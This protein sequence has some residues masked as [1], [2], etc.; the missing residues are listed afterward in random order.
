M[1]NTK[2]AFCKVCNDQRDFF[3]ESDFLWHC[4]ECENVEDANSGFEDEEEYLEA[5]EAFEDEYGE[6]VYCKSCKNFNVLE[7]ILEEGVCKVCFDE[8]GSV[9]EVKGYSYCDEKG[10]YCLAADED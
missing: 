10:E 1:A 5:L 7:N 9:L 6:A 8:L 4:D 2:E 3:L